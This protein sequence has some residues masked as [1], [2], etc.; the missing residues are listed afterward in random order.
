MYPSGSAANREGFFLAPAA[1]VQHAGRQKQSKGRKQTMNRW[2]TLALF[3][4]GGWVLC[5]V[6]T[7]C[8]RQK[9]DKQGVLVVVD[10]AGKEKKVKNWK[11][12]EGTK[13]L[14][15]VAKDAPEA[16][17]FFQGKIRPLKTSVLTF[18]PLDSIR[19]I[20]FE[21]QEGKQTMTV[22]VAI[23]DKEADDEILVG[24]TG[25]Q[26]FNYVHFTGDVEGGDKNPMSFEGGVVTDGIRSLRFA[27]P[28][29][30]GPLPKGR[31]ATV[32]N[33][34]EKYPSYT[35]AGL[36]ALYSS[37]GEWKTHPTLYF[38]DPTKY[39][40]DEIG[41]FTQMRSGG[42]NYQVTLLT[43]K[44]SYR[45]LLTEPKGPDFPAGHQFVG[46]VGRFAAGYRVFPIVTV[47]DVVFE[48][49]DKKK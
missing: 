11:F 31:T 20:D 35:V 18:V 5:S 14:S 47:G 33:N 43:G 13:R 1:E 2:S 49:T 4:A 44:K 42:N 6:T 7:L 37:G 16:L 3:L 28:K 46:F 8:A 9:D 45:T 10:V 34:N 21:P 48:D 39:N 24:P 22:R 25:W 29:P 12:S 23:S 27:A 17:E 26:G 32:V 15:W 38:N 19:R 41:K 40:L 30:V 36:E